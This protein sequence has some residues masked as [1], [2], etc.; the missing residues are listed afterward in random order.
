MC[1]T[2]RDWDGY[3]VQQVAPKKPVVRWKVVCYNLRPL[4]Q[5]QSS[6]YVFGQLYK[7]TRRTTKLTPTEYREKRIYK[8]IHVYKTRWRARLDK[9]GGKYKLIKVLCKPEDFVANSS[10]Q[11]VYFQV[12]PLEVSR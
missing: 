12:T 9:C 5:R 1:L 2:L 11:E 8:G 10:T 6:P 7:S 3:D 4:I